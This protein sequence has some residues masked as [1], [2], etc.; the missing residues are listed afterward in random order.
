MLKEA[1]PISLE[2]VVG[3]TAKI[4][5]EGYRFVTMSCTSLEENRLDILYHFDKDLE[6]KHFRLTIAKDTP[7][8]S[9]SPVYL[10]AFLVENEIQDLFGVRFSGLVLDYGQ[11]FYLEPEVK[12]AP[13]CKYSVNKA[14][15][16]SESDS[17]TEG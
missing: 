9:I 15:S 1:I 7:I 17:V 11:T 8:P 3:E 5:V 16:A 14:K 2:T 13:F 10:A 12:I 6:L 4:K